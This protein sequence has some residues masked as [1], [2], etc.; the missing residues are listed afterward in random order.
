LDGIKCASASDI[1]FIATPKLVASSGVVQDVSDGKG[2]SHIFGTHVP[3]PKFQ[4]TFCKKDGHT[5]KFGFRR[6][7]HERRVHAKAFK[8]PHNLSHGMCVSNV[9]TKSG[10]EVDASCS[11]FQGTS[12]LQATGDSSTW[13]VPPDRNLYHCSHC[14]KDGNQENFC[15]H[16]E[17]R[18]WRAGA[19]RPLVVHSPYHGMSTCAPKKAQ[20]VEGFYDTLSSELGHAHGHA[21]SASC[22][23]PR[24]VSR[25]ACVGSSHTTSRDLCLF[26]CGSTDFSSQVAPLRH[27][28]KSVQKPFLSN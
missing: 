10:V 6:V 25:G 4:R 9:G 22:V 28:S 11:K 5:V 23:G 20:F 8:K 16:W 19:S 21:S 26:A 15:Y 24:H 18:M 12:H 2:A 1:S 27:G 14:R 3:K 13:T 17:K 7:K